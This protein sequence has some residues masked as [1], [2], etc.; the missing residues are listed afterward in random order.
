VLYIRRGGTC[1]LDRIGGRTE[2]VRRDV[3]D[4][5]RL[6]GGV[7]GMPWRPTQTSGRGHCMA[8]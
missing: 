8:S 1:G 2:L 4:D 7:P 6:A 5:R 3:R